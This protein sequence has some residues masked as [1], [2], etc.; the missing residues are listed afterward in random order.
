LNDDCDYQVS[1]NHKQP[2]KNKEGNYCPIDGPIAVFLVDIEA[3]SV[4]EHIEK[5]E[6]LLQAS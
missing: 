1:Q 3:D 2:R 5:E 4:A 6:R